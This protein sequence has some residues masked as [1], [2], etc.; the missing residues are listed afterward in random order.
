MKK[1]PVIRSVVDP[2]PQSHDSTPVERR[3]VALWRRRGR[4]K[5]ASS[6]GTWR[7]FPEP[8]EGFDGVEVVDEPVK[9]GVSR[10]RFFET[11]GSGAA[12]A[13]LSIG[14][15]GCIRKPVEHI[16]PFSKR[17]EDL[18][19]GQP[20]QYAT[21]YQLGSSVEGILVES[22]D[23]RPTKVA[24]NPNHS[25][26][27]GATSVY[28]QATVYDI[29]DPDRSRY[30]VNAGEPAEMNADDGAIAAYVGLL[31][32]MKTKSGAGLGFVLPTV[33]SPSDRSLLK[34]VQETYPQAKFYLAD[35]LAPV[36]TWAATEMLG[37]P[38]ARARVQLDQAKVVFAADCN[39]FGLHPDATRLSLEWSSL[40]RVETPGDEMS[41]LYVCEPHLTNVGMMADHRVRVKAS[42]LKD[43]LLV[44]AE[45]L[46]KA[47]TGVLKPVPG[48]DFASLPAGT[49]DEEARKLIAAAAK[50]LLAHAAES[51]S[52]AVL[53]D[54]R[55]PAGVQAL[56]LAINGALGNFEHS[57]VWSVESDALAM[58]SL[59]DL[60]ADL[61][62]GATSTVVAIGA[63][64][65]HDG[66]P[67]LELKA[68]LEAANLFHFGLFRDE[69]GVV[70]DWHIP[71][72]HYLESWGDV[73][74][75]DG[76]VTICQPLIEPLHD[77]YSKTE[78]LAM[79]A[80]AGAYT[81]GYD[82]VRDQW[83]ETLGADPGAKRWS[84][85]LHDG[86][87]DLKAEFGTPTLDFS[88]VGAVLAK[89]P[90]AVDGW[91]VDVRPS[92]T[93]ADGRFY[94]NPWMRELP[95]PLSKLT[96]E[97]AAYVSPSAAAALGVEDEDLVTVKA[98]GGAITLPIKVAPGQ[99]DQTVTICAGFGRTIEPH[100]GVDPKRYAVDGDEGV[101]VAPLRS[102]VGPWGGAG[103][104]AVAGG[105][106]PLA[107]TQNYG[108][109]QPTTGTAAIDEQ[110]QYEERPIVL[111]MT[112]E[113]YRARPTYADDVYMMSKDR[114][115]HLFVSPEMTGA[116]QWA[117]SID[118]TTCTGCNACVIACQAENSIPTVGKENVSTGREMHWMRIDRY[119]RGDDDNPTA[120][121]QPMACQHC[122]SAP[123][124]TVCPV[125]ATEHSPEGLNDMV[126]N[127]CIGT[128][129]CSNNCPYKVRRFNFFNY[130]VDVRAKTFWNQ[131]LD[132]A[133]LLQMQRNPDVTIRFRGVME[134]CTYCVQRINQAKIA[135]HVAGEDTV[136]DGVIVTACQEVCPTRAIVFGDKDDPDSQISK[137]RAYPHQYQVLRDLNIRPRTTYLVHV[138]NPNPTLDRPIPG[139]LKPGRSDD[140]HG[141]G[142]GGGEHGG[143]GHEASH[144][145]TE[146]GSAPSHGNGDGHSAH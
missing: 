123:C 6:D 102:A 97:N 89:V 80:S 67:D 143:S 23:G 75:S 141:G 142:H 8:P 86:V 59:T 69:T 40:R 115:E 35:L 114:L 109:M 26:S 39:I 82:I 145:G 98:A 55:Q 64:P 1:L 21:A 20:M 53:V 126:Y 96:W 78:L 140:H 132:G 117:M 79:A 128:R 134:K 13:G 52:T 31:S 14:A 36:E 84:Q 72:S 113:D 7:E 91:E 58:G 12:L 112:Q 66:A 135:A 49:V 10:R 120:V 116:Q 144:P 76:T 33:L 124:E 81:K 16:L 47:D 92:P 28:T 3:S 61:K 77:T 73:Q 15:T 95:H 30:P 37:G 110:F 41:R 4:S 125:A 38:G 65:V 70:A 60:A 127:R 130:N 46:R 45:E 103:S 99:A 100:H 27:V 137:V 54:W 25:G 74:A 2:T 63:N 17:P 24:G 131:D 71:L 121:V 90:A 122:E 136:K 34:R 50:D 139:L 18:I 5:A 101:A 119:F 129:Y 107:D 22:H 62:A 85:W 29:Y 133:W 9:Q 11:M 111:E 106:H 51:K 118:L 19:P 104:I 48:F 42:A 32:E 146:H 93:I 43:V 44:L 105:R 108:S 56:A 94:N 138:R 57:I 83:R 88:G 68:L 87:A